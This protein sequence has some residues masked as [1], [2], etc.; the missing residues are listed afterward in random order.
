[1][2]R[3]EFEDAEII[4]DAYVEI[5]G[6]KY[7][8]IPP[9][10]SGGTDLN[11]KTFNDLQDNMENALNNINTTIGDINTILASVVNGE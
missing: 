11:K 3:I 10:T 5:A 2:E 1:M 4:E 7:Y 8:V 6:V 9:Q